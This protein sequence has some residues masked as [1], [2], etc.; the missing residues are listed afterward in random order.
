MT[1]V[2]AEPAIAHELK[3]A[4]LSFIRRLLGR[5]L[6]LAYRLAGADRYDDYR[7]ELIR[8]ARFVVMPSVFNPRVTRT[9]AFLAAQIDPGALQGHWEVLDMGTGSGVG[10]VIAARHARRVV[11]V[12]INPAAVRCA[13][14]NALLNDV[15]QRI[16]V[17]QGDLFAALGD[18]R[19]DLVLF[20]PPFVR[21]LPRSDRD[22]AWSAVDVAERFAEGLER[23][24]K[25]AGT[26][27]I[28]L[29]TFGNGALYLRELQRHGLTLSPL[30]ERRF[31]NER[32][33]VFKVATPGVPR[34]P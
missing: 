25:P 15:E 13:R 17:R 27:L 3:V 29:S 31:V 11:A 7:V 8:G 26:A 24:L 9:G 20:N 10:A 22:R 33:T 30:A 14:I 2:Q 19:F 4:P 6:H 23:H 34:S 5:A 28:V 12:D 21:A 1:A 32:L 18:E 16:E